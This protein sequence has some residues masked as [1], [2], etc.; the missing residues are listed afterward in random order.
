MTDTRTFELHRDIDISGV[1][2]TGP[3]ADGVVFPDGTTVLHWRPRRGD[4]LRGS[5]SVYLSLA[6]LEQIHGHRG[7]TR[8]VWTD[9][10]ARA[11]PTPAE[12]AAEV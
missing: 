8:V 1:S 12:I 7:A 3:V 2:G 4:G 9:P 11:Y 6:H 5:T 10:L